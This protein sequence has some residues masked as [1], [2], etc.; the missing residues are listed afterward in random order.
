MRPSCSVRVCMCVHVSS[1]GRHGWVSRAKLQCPLHHRTCTTCFVCVCVC[2]CVTSA[3]ACV[4][5]TCRMR[6]HECVCVC[7]CVCVTHTGLG[8]FTRPPTTGTKRPNAALPLAD[9]SFN[10]PLLRAAMEAYVPVM[11]P[12]AFE[13]PGGPSGGAASGEWV[14]SGRQLLESLPLSVALQAGTHTH[15]HTHSQTHRP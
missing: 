14:I 6:L 4:P 2:V 7:V 13:G 1:C 12:G 11:T 8:G 9:A 3:W 10:P 5:R 15:T